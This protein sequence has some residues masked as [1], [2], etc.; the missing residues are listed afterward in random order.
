M[1]TD[2]WKLIQPIVEDSRGET[3]PD[4]Y[5]QERSPEPLLFDLV[6]DPGETRERGGDYPD[7]LAAMSAELGQWRAD[8][9]RLTGEA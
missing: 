2:R 1:R 9:L 7:Q 4:F 3:L 8:T 6:A 5:G